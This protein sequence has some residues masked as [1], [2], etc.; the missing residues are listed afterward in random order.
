MPNDKS[1][2]ELENA[3]QQEAGGDCVSRLVR[4][5]SNDLKTIAAARCICIADDLT[6]DEIYATRAWPVS[7]VMAWEVG[8]ALSKIHKPN[9]QGQAIRTGSAT[10]TTPK[11]Q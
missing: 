10:P 3:T 6:A 9:D 2:P 7:V 8:A 5:S 4:L 11:P 1:P